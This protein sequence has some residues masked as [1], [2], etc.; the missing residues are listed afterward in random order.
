VAIDQLRAISQAEGY[1]TLVA[2]SLKADGF[3]VQTG[4]PFG[5]APAEWIVEETVLRHIDL[6]VMA[7][8]DRIGPDR[9]VHGS[10][11]EAVV[12]RSIAP[13]MLVRAT[14]A[15][16]FAERFEA[17]QPVLIVPLDGSQLAESALPIARELTQALG[18]RVVLVAV[19]PK[20]GKLVAGQGGA[21]VTYVGSE[22]AELEAEAFAYLDASI[23]RLGSIGSSVEK[24]VRYGDASTEIAAVAHE[25]TA[26]AVVMATHGRAGLVRS[27][28]GSVA[29]GVLHHSSSPVVLIHPAEL[30]AAEEPIRQVTAAAAAG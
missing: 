29:G 16:P 11:A 10:V 5:G 12:H 23:G 19:V 30:R 21:I 7:T 9:W 2:D 28:L 17:P 26:A 13:V 20:P 24:I 14:D 22:Y 18:G 4:V 8:H 6:I 15:A 27:L 25:Y 3:I 1:L